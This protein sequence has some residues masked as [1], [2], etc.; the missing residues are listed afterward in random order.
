MDFIIQKVN[1]R[2]VSGLS[3][4]DAVRVFQEA[5]EPIMVQ[6]LRRPAH[7]NNNN[8]NNNNN[9]SSGST[10]NASQTQQQSTSAPS[11]PSHTATPNGTPSTSAS[12][13]TTT[14]ASGGA[15]HHHEGELHAGPTATTGTQT[16]MTLMGVG[17]WEVA[18]SEWMGGV[19]VGSDSDSPDGDYVFPGDLPQS[20]SQFLEQEIDIEVRAKA[21]TSRW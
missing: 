17:D 18:T 20:L 11:S 2:D 15:H 13:C 14:A 8:N 1:G 19:G 12:T 21:I 9:T 16:E 4:S 7:N 5:Q 3:H 10:P 6:V